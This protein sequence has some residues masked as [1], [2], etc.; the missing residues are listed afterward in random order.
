[1]AFLQSELPPSTAPVQPSRA[2]L[3]QD[4]PAPVSQRRPRSKLAVRLAVGMTAATLFAIPGYLAARA[5]ESVAIGILAADFAFLLAV[6][7][8]SSIAGGRRR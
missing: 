6:A 1:M 3:R 4:M 5:T 8:W 2:A 7:G